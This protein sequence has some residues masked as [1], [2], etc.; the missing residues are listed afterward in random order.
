MKILFIVKKEIISIEYAGLMLISAVLK[1]AGYTVRGV[2]E[3]DYD[4]IAAVVSEF[5][6][7]IIGFSMTTGQHQY[8][9]DLVKRLKRT[10]SFISIFGG[11]HPTYFPEVINEEGVDIVCVGEGEYPMLELVEHVSAGSDYLDIPNLII[12]KNGSTY[13][14]PPR[15]FLQELDLLPFEDRE[16][17][18]FPDYTNFAI[19]ANR[20]CP[21][22]CSYCFNHRLKKLAAGRYIRQ[23]SVENVIAELKMLR[24][25]YNATR[26]EFQDDIFILDKK[27]L[28][29]FAERYSTEIG[30]PFLCHVR[31]NLVTREVVELL[32]KAGC[33]TAVMGVES[34]NSTMREQIL[35]R[36][37]S[38]EMIIAAGKLFQKSGIELLTQNIIALP[39]ET[40]EM[41]FDTV[42]VN[43]QIK[44]QH[45]NLYF[46]QPYPGTEIEKYAVE[47]GFFTAD[48]DG[49][50]ESANARSNNKIPINTPEAREFKLL[51]DIF[52]IL[53]RFPILFRYARSALT[54]RRDSH[55]NRIWSSFVSLPIVIFS[56]LKINILRL[57]SH[58]QRQII[59]R[60][61]K[62]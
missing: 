19:L 53:V 24:N 60:I 57:T 29:E 58:R 36:R 34:G 15:P 46:C 62:L 59:R 14:N 52:P 37:M 50:P 3:Q 17:F 6:P 35:N 5:Q 22:N 61:L 13:T 9:V 26:I 28:A 48:F 30:L 16:L 40:I 10:F 18:G 42:D 39:G 56:F 12:K 44:P 7:N 4:L 23:R 32:K 27:W 20:G 8:Y 45:M 38:T 21:N 55:F 25:S 11:P 41:A 43:I 33:T 1:K 31:A 51:S 47:N 2:V 49:F 54:L